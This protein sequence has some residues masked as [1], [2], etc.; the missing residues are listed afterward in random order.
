M[1]FPHYERA[2]IGIR[3]YAEGERERRRR[4]RERERGGGEIRSGKA[5]PLTDNRGHSSFSSEIS[6]GSKDRPMKDS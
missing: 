3:I 2:Y 6:L 4:E 1:H 5:I